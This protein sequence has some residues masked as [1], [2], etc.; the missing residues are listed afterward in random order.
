MVG[1]IPVVDVQPVVG[2]GRQSAKATVGEPFPVSATVFREGHDK[3][4]A[5]VV[6]IAP[7]GSRQPPARMAKLTDPVDRYEAWVTPTSTGA[8][9]FEVHAWSDPFATWEHAAS[10]KVPAGID[11]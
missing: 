6:L 10:I 5:E 7:D 4:A 9:T 1:R 3:L 11:V 2:L 8:W